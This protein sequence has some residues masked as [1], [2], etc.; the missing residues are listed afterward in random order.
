VINQAFCMIPMNIKTVLI[1]VALVAAGVA[2][3][4]Y[5]AKKY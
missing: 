5:Y 1:Y 4:Y 3:G 2:G